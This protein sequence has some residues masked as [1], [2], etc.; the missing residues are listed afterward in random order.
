MDWRRKDA[1][2]RKVGKQIKCGSCYAFAAVAAIESHYFIKT[3][4]KVSLSSQHIVD[5]SKL[6]GNFG[7][8]GGYA[9]SAFDYVRDHGVPA[10]SAYPYVDKDNGLC[11]RAK[12]S[13]VKINGYATIQSGSEKELQ[14]ALV[15]HGPIVVSIDTKGHDFKH[16]SSGIYHDPKCS[17]T[18]DDL[19]HSVLLVGYGTDKYHRDYW[20]LKNWWGS[21]WGE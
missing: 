10:D 18:M 5:C 20:I 12:K 16:Y 17:N 19:D 13:K 4:Q 1:V 2:N 14:K 9:E 11:K 7:C 6:Y 21:K 15:L 8:D 3:R